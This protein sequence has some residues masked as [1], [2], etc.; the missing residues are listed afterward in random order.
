MSTVKQRFSHYKN[1]F[2]LESPRFVFSLSRFELCVTLASTASTFSNGID[3]S[4][5]FFLIDIGVLQ[6]MP[7][8]TFGLSCTESSTS[9]MELLNI[10]L[11]YRQKPK[12]LWG[13]G[14]V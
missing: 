5:L 12:P 8:N 1:S 3:F 9:Q 7:M 4:I 2:A 6:R 13:L 11:Y 10:G 14:L